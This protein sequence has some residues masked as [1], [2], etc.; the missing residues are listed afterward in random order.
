MNPSTNV[1][2]SSHA[3]EAIIARAIDRAEVDI[4]LASYEFRVPDALPPKEVLMRRYMD[5]EIGRVA[6]MRVVIEESPLEIVILTVYKTT[7]MARYLRG[8][9]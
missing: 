4:T 2:W 1:R 5:R 9:E 7:Q 8:F 6:L 3:E